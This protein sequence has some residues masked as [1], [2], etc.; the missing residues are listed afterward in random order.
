MHIGL[1][2]QSIN[3]HKNGLPQPE[4]FALRFSKHKMYPCQRIRTSPSLNLDGMCAPQNDIPER[5]GPRAAEHAKSQWETSSSSGST[6]C[7]VLWTGNIWGPLNLAAG[8]PLCDTG[9]ERDA[10]RGSS[11]PIRDPG[12]V[13]KELCEQFLGFYKAQGKPWWHMG[14]YLTNEVLASK[15]FKNQGCMW[16]EKN[17]LVGDRC[18]SWGVSDWPIPRFAERPNAVRTFHQMS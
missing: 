5:H 6:W 1:S 9:V 8:M 15:L 12:V 10:P 13:E 2:D 18:W 4:G 7:P 17:K 11:L 3:R 16:D 14:Y